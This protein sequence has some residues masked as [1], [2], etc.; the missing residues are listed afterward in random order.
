MNTCVFIGRIA[1]DLDPQESN[2]TT[3]LRFRIAVRRNRSKE[4]K[5][6]FIPCKAFNKTAEFI[7]KYFKKGD[8]IWVVASY[9]ADQ[10][11]DNDGNTRHTHDFIVNEAGFC[12]SS[13]NGNNGEDRDTTVNSSNTTTAGSEIPFELPF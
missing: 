13:R 6:D 8:P 7:A 9:R 12:P 10:Y 4:D 3:Y 11:T 5:A 1:T 2:G